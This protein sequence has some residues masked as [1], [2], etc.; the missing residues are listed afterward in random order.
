M[1]VNDKLVQLISMSILIISGI[2]LLITDNIEMNR[3]G[4]SYSNA[5]RKALWNLPIERISILTIYKY[6]ILLA[7]LMISS[8]L[9]FIASRRIIPINALKLGIVVFIVFTIF[10]FILAIVCDY[11]VSYYQEDSIK[12]KVSNNNNENENNENNKNENENKESNE[13]YKWSLRKRNDNDNNDDNDDKRLPVTLITGFL[14]SGKTTLIN[15]ILNNTIGMKILVI[16][17]EI[18]KEGIDHELLVQQT[19]KEEVILLNN[20]CVCC[21]VR[22]DIL[23]TFQGLFKNEAFSRLDWVIIETTG[24]ANPA[25]LIQTLYMDN[26]CKQHLRLDS[27]L[28]MVD[29]KHVNEHLDS[30][31]KGAHGGLS[32]AILQLSYADR[33]ILNKIDLITK[34]QLDI[35]AEKV[36]AFNPSANIIACERS[37]VPIEKILNLRAFDATRNKALLETNYDKPSFIKIDSDGKIITKKKRQNLN[38]HVKDSNIIQTVS[39]TTEKPLNLDKFNNFIADVLRTH[40]EQLYRLKG[41]L[42]MSGFDNQF[43]AQGVHMVFDGSLGPVWTSNDNRKSTLVLIGRKLDKT[44]LQ[45]KFMECITLN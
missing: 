12:E 26:D 5:L 43:V 36:S 15:E 17:N 11:I 20:G 1:I 24:L 19:A 21:S 14:G 27:V 29:S 40:G 33:I 9:V 16:E 38:E 8:S 44:D 4:K 7:S 32:E 42:S 2:T 23:T 6:K 3:K 35:L 28:T 10:C 45:T 41:I 30:K 18:G 34:D 37:K 13:S 39:L 25:P 31:D 22:K